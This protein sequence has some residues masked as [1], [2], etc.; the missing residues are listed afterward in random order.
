MDSGEDR[1]VQHFRFQDS[2]AP[3]TSRRRRRFFSLLKYLFI[4]EYVRAY[5]CLWEIMI[6]VLDDDVVYID[7]SAYVS[8]FWPRRIDC[9]FLLLV[10]S[11]G[12]WD[13]LFW[14]NFCSDFDV[15][16]E[17][18]VLACIGLF[19]VIC[20]EEEMT[21]SWY[22]FC[23]VSRFESEQCVLLSFSLVVLLRPVLFVTWKPG[24]DDV[25]SIYA[26]PEDFRDMRQSNKAKGLHLLEFF[27]NKCH[28]IGVNTLSLFSSNQVI[29]R[30][31]YE[32]LC[33]VSH[34]NYCNFVMFYD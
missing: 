11:V 5:V 3:R 25:D 14:T 6:L 13:Y 2:L 15:T 26:S 9:A 7:R 8:E 18:D 19:S 22:L 17:E 32:L 20:L 30:C 23:S 34:C 28:E 29:L 10:V 12:R 24:F 33:F 4:F 16:F 27:V 21:L 31:V 1:K